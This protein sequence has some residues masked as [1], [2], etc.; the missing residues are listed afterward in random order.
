MNIARLNFSHGNHEYHG[1]LI[2]NIRK[3]NR[4]VNE[5]IAP[6][7]VSVAIALDTKGPEIRTGMLVGG[8]RAEVELKVKHLI[9][10]TTDE[11][12]RDCG[13]AEKLYVDYA[14][15]TKVVKVGDV[16][17]IDDGQISLIAQKVC[18]KEIVCLVEHGGLLGSKKGVN[19][20]GTSVDLPMVSDKDIADLR[21]GVTHKVDMVFAS[22]IRSAAGVQKIRQVLGDDG[23]NILVIAKVENEEGC[24]NADEIIAASDGVMVARGDL[25]IEI[26]P[27]QVFCV[28]KMLIVKC[29]SA[30]KP[31]ICA[32]QMLESMTK[33]PRPT[34]A[35]TCDVA[36]AVLDGAD[37]VMLSGETAKGDFPVRTV[38]T[39]SS[40]CLRAEE[41]YFYRNEFQRQ[42]EIVPPRMSMEDTLA[43]AAVAASQACMAR[44]IVVATVN[45]KGVRSIARFRPRCPIIVVL[46]SG[47]L[48]RSLLLHRAVMTLVHDWKPLED[49]LE[50][51]SAGIDFVLEIGPK[52]AMFEKADIV[53][54]VL[55]SE[56]APKT[57]RVVPVSR[58]EIEKVHP[59]DPPVREPSAE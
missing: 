38:E 53:V 51:L 2:A 23:K 14:N 41:L 15:I 57:L 56:N 43:A 8:A 32:T 54:T 16:I 4:I 22:F 50:D 24:E 52:R 3:A 21:F 13:T 59:A 20:P 46:R 45:G 1:R 11:K 18:A 17:F 34:R 25:G 10:L 48:A 9:T 44:A 36:N 33:K 7:T 58:A 49:P 35:E 40:I 6:S 19:L 55:D 27:E 5:R 42:F 31:V 12:L 29:N 47:T 28:Q 39:M 26:A 30:G 37:C